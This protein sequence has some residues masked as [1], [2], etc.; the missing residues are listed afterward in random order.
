MPLGFPKPFSSA[1]HTYISTPHLWSMMTSPHHTTTPAHQG[2]PKL[3][4]LQGCRTPWKAFSAHWDLQGWSPHQEP[5]VSKPMPIGSPD[6]IWRSALAGPGVGP[7]IRIFKRGGLFHKVLPLLLPLGTLLVLQCQV[8]PQGTCESFP[9]LP[10]S[11][12]P[13]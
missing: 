9:S 12:S 11:L 13:D 3:H 1:P 8:K 5:W 6:P 7:G 2:L 10:P 4:S